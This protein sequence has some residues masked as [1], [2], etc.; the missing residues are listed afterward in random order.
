MLKCF[1]PGLRASG[2]RHRRMD[3]TTVSMADTIEVVSA[4][5]PGYVCAFAYILGLNMLNTGEVISL[6][7]TLRQF[8]VIRHN[9]LAQQPGTELKIEIVNGFTKTLEKHYTHEAARRH[10]HR[11]PAAFPTRVPSLRAGS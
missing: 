2:A 5:T 7:A 6:D 10:P 4:S 11:V 9:S 3:F 1:E 8:P